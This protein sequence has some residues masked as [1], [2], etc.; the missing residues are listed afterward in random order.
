M[1]NFGETL[2]K[3]RTYKGY[4]Q[5]E[6]AKI[7][8]SSKQV[9]SRYENSLRSPDILIAQKWAEKLNIPVK[10]LA[11]DSLDVVDFFSKPQTP[12]NL[13]P[14]KKVR[15]V[16][17]IG[18]IACGTPILA[19]E[20]I[21]DH[22]LLPDGVKADYALTCEGDSMMDAGI[23]SDDIVFIR[24]QPE[25]EN[26]EIAA[27]LIGEEATLKKVYF[28]GKKLSLLPANANYDPFVYVGE[29]INQVSI[30]GKAVAV[31]KILE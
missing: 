7:V 28:S 14:L 2:K 16:P 5:E 31:L 20:N 10:Y 1:A 17:L 3:Y 21:V 9:V 6:L 23:D 11:D 26:G 19:E 25:V 15:Y 4:T 18:R 13:V 22:I 27:V 30:L 12:S 8:G 29:E 24:Q